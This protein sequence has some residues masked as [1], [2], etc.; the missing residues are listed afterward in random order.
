MYI[1]S[2]DDEGD[3]SL[4]TLEPRD[5]HR[6]LIVDDDPS[7][8]A[9]LS[10]ALGTCDLHCQEAV[11]GVEALE[12][13]HRDPVDLVI[14]DVDMPRMKGTEVLRQIRAANAWPH[15]KIVMISGRA[16]A[17]EMA[18]MMLAGA[19]DYIAKPF[20]RTQLVAR[21]KTALHLKDEQVRADENQRQL[22][23]SYRNL[24]NK[25]HARNTDLLHAR[26]SLVVAL[27]ELVACRDSET[28]DHLMRLQSYSGLLAAE[29]RKMPKFAEQI[30]DHFIELLEC[31]VPLHDIGKAA[32]PDHILQKPG[33]L[34]VGE[35]AV[36]KTHT[37]IGADLLAR[38]G[39]KRRFARDFLSM[40]IDITRHHH[41]RFDGNGYP[42]CLAGEQ[43]PL[44]ARIVA[45]ADVY[46]A[47]RS[48]RIYKP[49]MA[50]ADTMRIMLH[51]SI[52]HFDPDLLVAFEKCASRFA[53]LYDQNTNKPGIARPGFE[54][55]RN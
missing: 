41:E 27:A 33:K 11:D 7:N 39:E 17:D 55:G 25:L 13:L 22:L 6:I 26:D 4:G 31:C 48:P 53:E 49:A 28:G 52:G 37:V 10:I 45:I 46:D 32:I 43:I 50:H 19:D 18:N 34:T 23:G 8:R 2:Q 29:A 21:V 15:L 20:T 47:I 9:L 54:S 35:F 1:N 42:D 5:S 14:L 30:D 44:A 12:I 3:T 24:E 40:G 38:V 36:M 51:E 16:S